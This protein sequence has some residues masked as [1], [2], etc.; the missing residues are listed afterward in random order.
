MDADG[1]EKKKLDEIFDAF[2]YEP[3]TGSDFIRMFDEEND[4]TFIDTFEMPFY[5]YSHDAVKIMEIFNKHIQPKIKS[6]LDRRS[7]ETLN[8]KEGKA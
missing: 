4:G 2:D 6:I 7:D 8:D 1:E 5:R 3:E